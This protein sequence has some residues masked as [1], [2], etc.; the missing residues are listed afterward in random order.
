MSQGKNGTILCLFSPR[1]LLS[2]WMVPAL[3]TELAAND[4]MQFW[5]K[6][7]PGRHITEL[8]TLLRVSL[9]ELNVYHP[10]DQLQ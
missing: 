2:R 6:T 10:N 8:Q 7:L 4:K 5:A 9:S 3:D 1:G